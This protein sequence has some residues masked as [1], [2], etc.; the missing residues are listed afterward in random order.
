MA[1]TAHPV[2]AVSL[3][4]GKSANVY[5]QD[6]NNSQAYW[7]LDCEVAGAALE[8]AGPVLGAVGKG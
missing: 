5:K 3:S 7:A 4:Q 2:S 6:G 1:N 8:E